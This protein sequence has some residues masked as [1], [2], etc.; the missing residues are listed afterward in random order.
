LKPL[1]VSFDPATKRVF[2]TGGHGFIGRAV[3]RI[4]G[5]LGTQVLAPNRDE[6]DVRNAA[7]LLRW[8]VDA[9]PHAI[10]HCAG[11]VGSRAWLQ[12][13]DAAI[14]DDTDGMCDAMAQ[15]L[16]H[17]H[18]ERIVSVGSTAAY[19]V[20]APRPLQESSFFDGQVDDRIAG[21]AMSKRRTALVFADIDGVD[22]S[23]VLPCNIYGPGQRTCGDR[24]NVVGAL[25]AKFTLAVGEAQRNVPCWGA[26]ASREFLHVDDCA[27]GIVDA[28]KR[29]RNEVVN[30]GSGACTSIRLLTSI[31]SEASGFTGDLSWQD[32]S[33][34]TDTLHACDRRARSMLAWRP[35]ISLSEGV[36]ETV[37]LHGVQHT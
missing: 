35:A 26:H 37:R 30:L 18:V 31:I 1:P 3:V 10:V 4:L 27:A 17:C 34:S 32:E 15:A 21:Y 33:A 8:M 6:L 24:A 28:L 5:S 22:A 16:R 7:H 13:N 19:A 11:V 2:V 25:T 12:A 9:Q 36:A 20:D 23:C 29:L 14:K